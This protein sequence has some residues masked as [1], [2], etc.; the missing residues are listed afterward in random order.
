MKRVKSLLAIGMAAAVLAG[1]TGCG[2]KQE[3]Q[4]AASAGQ[5]TGEAVS[6]AGAEAEGSKKLVFWDKSEYVAAYN[7]MMKA[8]VDEFAAENGVEVDYVI[9]PSGD[10][11]QKLA[12]AIE[13]GNQPDLIMGDNTTVAEYV[14][15]GQLADVSDVVEGIDYKETARRYAIFDDTD[16]LIPLSLTAPGMYMRKD[17]WEEHNLQVPKTW[18]EFR[19]HA[20]TINDP[21][22]GF[23]ALGLP[24]GA[25]GGGDAETF[26]RTV[27]LDFG[28]ALVDESG[29][30]VV[31][32]PETLAA[33]EYIASLYNEG[34]CPPDA[35][36]WDDSANNS[37][38]LAGTVGIVCNSGSIITSMEEEN[39]E[40]LA[41]TNII[42][43]PSVEEGGISYALG[44]AN[45]F[46]IFETGKNTQVAKDFV[47]YYFSDSDYYNQ[48]VEA[49][50]AMW[51]PV[52]NGYDD[53]EFWNAE[54]HIGWLQNS[55][56]L[57]LTT[58]PAPV[59]S[60]AAVAFSNQLAT[61]TMQEIVV[62]KTDPQE[63]LDNL[64]AELKK[65]YE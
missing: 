62:N 1:V 50:G 61:K 16:Y 56:N 58:Y 20:R 21:E 17:V 57:V 55:Q 35:T 41:N 5:N 14:T 29:K 13:S 33:L 43:Y 53:T 22:N 59:E 37:A 26:V 49:M 51:Q 12:A 6:E 4:D 19:E 47:S 18:E 32:S 8:K 28:G 44:G 46:G 40:L 48:M 54:N 23:Y 10:L 60:K 2:S 38:Y 25:S 27:I 63:A 11:K 24:L 3:S 52:I 30:V 15:T 7:D 65:I 36:T 64:E 34:L 9:V 31:N 39:P 45:V 42:Q